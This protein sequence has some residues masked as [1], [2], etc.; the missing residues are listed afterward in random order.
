MTRLSK[1]DRERAI[2]M[3]QVGKPKL[4]V[5]QRFG[6]TVRTI[7]RLWHRF[8]QTGSTSDSPRSGRPRVTIPLEDRHIRL[9]HL[10]DR[11]LCAT[12]T[13]RT[14]PGSSKS[15]QTVG[16][17][18][19]SGRLRARRP[20]AGPV[21]T[22]RHRANRLN[23]DRSHRRWLLRQWNNVMFSDEYRFCL[24]HGDWRQRLWRRRGERFAGPLSR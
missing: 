22:R 13:A 18:L 2:S 10:R 4:Q 11:F 5:A 23:W 17:Q 12:V 3:L 15:A 24:T 21:L 7:H 16:N 8:N 9:R 1:E 20:Y 19:K 14:F 6:C